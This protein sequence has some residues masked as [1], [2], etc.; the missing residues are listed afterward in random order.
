MPLFQVIKNM[1]TTTEIIG[2]LPLIGGE[3]PSRAYSKDRVCND[4]G[5]ETKLSMYNRGK[6]C[7]LH[8]PITVPRTRGRKI[9]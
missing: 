9:A 4:A 7:Y 1:A 5:C 6:F 3:K 2:A 8:Q